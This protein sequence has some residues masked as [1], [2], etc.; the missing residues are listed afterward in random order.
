MEQ[1]SAIQLETFRH[2]LT[3]FII[4]TDDEWEIFRQVLYL[5][6]FKKKDHFVE[7]GRVCNDVG[8]ILKGSFRFYN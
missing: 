2:F 7:A 1:L 5:K 4:F 8:F 3:T 6:K